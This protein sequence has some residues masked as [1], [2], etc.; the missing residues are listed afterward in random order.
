[1]ILPPDLSEVNPFAQYRLENV[2]HVFHAVHGIK[3]GK[4][5]LR[6]AVSRSMLVYFGSS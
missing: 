2:P 5:P 6:R 3:N 1:M 4:I